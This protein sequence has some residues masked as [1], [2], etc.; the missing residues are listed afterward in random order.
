M[1][2]ERDMA[3]AVLE[4]ASS[5]RWPTII[6]EIAC[7]R[8]CDRVTVTIGPAKKPNLLSSTVKVAHVRDG[9]SDLLWSSLIPFDNKLSSMSFS[10]SLMKV[11]SALSCLT[12]WNVEY[13]RERAEFWTFCNYS[14]SPI[15]FIIDSRERKRVSLTLSLFKLITSSL[16]SYYI[17]PSRS[18]N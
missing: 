8:Y 15:Y 4:R 18:L 9:V 3:I 14:C 7:K 5:P 6:I 13:V 10:V 11:L 12:R 2:P 1:T 16:L 17:Y